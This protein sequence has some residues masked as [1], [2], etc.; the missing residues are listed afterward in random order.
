M[1][2]SKEGVTGFAKTQ[3]EAENEDEDERRRNSM[4]QQRVRHPP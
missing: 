3:E 4:K 2:L 1:Y